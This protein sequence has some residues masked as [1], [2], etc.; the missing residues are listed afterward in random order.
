ME[1]LDIAREGYDLSINRYKEVVHEEVDQRKPQV[2]LDELE[3]IEKEI[4]TGMK[5]LRRMLN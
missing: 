4:T 1:R 5:E 3:S 2:I